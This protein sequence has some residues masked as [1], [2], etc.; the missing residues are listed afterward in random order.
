MKYISVIIVM[1]LCNLSYGQD[2]TATK[3]GA[4]GK[5]D[6]RKASWGMSR[7]QVK[8]LETNFTNSSEK[9]N[10]IAYNTQLAGIDC[11]LFYY[12]TIDNE[13]FEGGFVFT[14]EHSNLNDHIN[15]FTKLKKLLEIKY[16]TP[17]LDKQVWKND[18][19]KDNYS[20]WGI[21][22]SAGQM[23]YLASWETNT[24]I[25]RMILGGDNAEIK[26]TL[27]YASKQRKSLEEDKKQKKI[28]EEL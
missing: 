20:R 10:Y 17:T 26:F 23:A 3:D 6:F 18:L 8:I 19:F 16:G 14:E 27:K 28:L 11:S 5:A 2:T 4:T 9:E 24:T 25:V 15:D 21:A 7:E 13:L 1:L 12:F 22:M